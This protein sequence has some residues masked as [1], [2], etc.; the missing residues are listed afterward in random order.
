MTE[1][2]SISTA[3]KEVSESEFKQRLHEYSRKIK[4]KKV[5]VP[6]E[7]TGTINQPKTTNTL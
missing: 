7:P 2:Y 3:A 1:Y 5:I 6:N 4:N